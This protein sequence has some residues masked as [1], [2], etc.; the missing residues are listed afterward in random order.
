[1][2]GHKNKCVCVETML[3]ATK[4]MC[5]CALST[6]SMSTTITFIKAKSCA[7]L[8]SAEFMVHKFTDLKL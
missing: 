8:I 6:I 1:M 2:G 5:G 7:D 3:R 4:G